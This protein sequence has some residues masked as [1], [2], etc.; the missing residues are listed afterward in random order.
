MF[1]V[2]LFSLISLRVIINFEFSVKS[3]HLFFFLLCHQLLDTA[4]GAGS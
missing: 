4:H 2:R 3:S 1:V